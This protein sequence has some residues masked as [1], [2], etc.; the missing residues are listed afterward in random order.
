MALHVFASRKA[1]A[2]PCN[3]FLERP[4]HAKNYAKHDK[5]AQ[6]IPREVS[7]SARWKQWRGE[8]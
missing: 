8:N 3:L 6:L 4:R 7:R 5:V 2:D 1:A